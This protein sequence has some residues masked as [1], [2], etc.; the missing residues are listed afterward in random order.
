MSTDLS[1][2]Q[3]DADRHDD[4]DPDDVLSD[5]FSSDEALPD[6]P[7]DDTVEVRRDAPLLA[8][9]GGTAA[10]VAVAYLFRAVGTGGSVLDAALGLVVAVIAAVFLAAFADARAPLVVIDH[11]GVR[12]RRGRT[13]RGVAWDDVDRME[14][15]P[16][17]SLLGDGSLAVVD[18]D[19]QVLAVRLSLSTRLTGSDWHE[20]GDAL[21]DLSE[22]RTTVVEPEPVEAVE[23]VE[24]HVPAVPDVERE[25]AP[26][27]RQEVVLE[28][29]HRAPRETADETEV[30]ALAAVASDPSTTSTIVIAA[31]DVP[32][33]P[34]DPVVGPVLAAARQRV[35]LTVDQLAERTR[36][37]PH[38]IESIELDDFGPC[39]G[40]F[41]AR[42]HLRTLA[43]ILGVDVEPLLADYDER[44]ADA[45]IDPRRVFEAELA[46]TSGGAIHGTRGR[47]NW[48]VLVAAVMAAVL[49]WSLARLLM[50]A[51]ATVSDQPVLNGSPG[52]R[53]QLAGASTERVPV[54]F[55]AATGGARVVVRDANQKVV[56]DENVAFNQTAKVDAVPPVRISSTDGGLTV[57]V[58]GADQGAM[59]STGNA[60]QR[61]YVVR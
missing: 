50:D 48:S 54:S 11:Q 9:I 46:T 17:T 29:A 30:I 53:A 26:A 15:Q 55:T 10:V 52:G 4:V 58:D 32:A 6:E 12:V 24:P 47:L 59:G 14:H 7:Y 16:R 1:N 20:L 25:L 41:Y 22:G 51:P 44:Y 33:T 34:V 19:E 2:P 35:G 36:I 21:L 18:V 57:T 60:A 31:D 27:R 39:G 8:L 5:E 49:V 3:H 28:K 45:P 61:T 38:V 13:W 56:F 40:D 37:R 23:P 43:R 42:G